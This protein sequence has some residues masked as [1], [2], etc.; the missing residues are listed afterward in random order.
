MRLRESVVFDT[1]NY[2]LFQFH[3][4]AIKRLDPWLAGIW[5]AEFQFHIGAIKSLSN[6]TKLLKQT[7]FQF[8]IGAI[9]SVKFRLFNCLFYPFQFHIGAIKSETLHS[10]GAD[11]FDFNSTLVRLRDEYVREAYLEKTF[12]FHIGAIKSD[13]EDIKDSPEFIS[14]PHWCD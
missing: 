2:I 12:Q 1:I 14:I 7:K 10:N 4:G 5:L 11:P 6:R 9:K 8:H 13:I 3:I